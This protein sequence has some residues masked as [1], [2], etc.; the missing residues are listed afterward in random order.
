M[1]ERLKYSSKKLVR[2][3]NVLSLIFSSL[4]MGELKIND[5]ALEFLTKKEQQSG[6]YP[7]EKS[8]VHRLR[9]GNLLVEGRESSLN[10][11]FFYRWED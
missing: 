7:G 5:N 9:V 10:H 11:F 3:C 2:D 8:Q 1:E 4:R 6:A